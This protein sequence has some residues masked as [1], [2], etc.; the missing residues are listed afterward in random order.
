[1]ERDG[2]PLSLSDI[3]ALPDSSNWVALLRERI[4]EIGFAEGEE[5]LP[6]LAR[7]IFRAET[8]VRNTLSGGLS[9]FVGPSGS[10]I[11]EARAIHSAMVRIGAPRMA[12]VLRRACDLMATAPASAWSDE[13]S[14]QSLALN[15][16]EE[17][18]WKIGFDEPDGA[19]QDFVW[20][21]RSDFRAT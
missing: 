21:H 9:N 1:M 5:T 19:V 10:T 17:E 6:E 2:R 3:V 12:E 11:A 14:A 20:R 16:L 4:L 13:S 15:E 8:I 7:V 18:F